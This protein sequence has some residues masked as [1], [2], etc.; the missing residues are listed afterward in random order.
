MHEK[1]SFILII[2]E[3]LKRYSDANNPLSQ[4]DIAKYAEQDYSITISRKAIKSNLVELIELGYD[5]D[6]AETKRVGKNGIEDTI[7]SD[8]YFN[9]DFSDAELRFLIDYLLSTKLLPYSQ[10]MALIQKLENTS[11]MHF[12]EKMRATKALP[13]HQPEKSAFFYNLELLDEAIFHEKKISFKL[14]LPGINSITQQIPAGEAT[15]ASPYELLTK[16][17]KHYLFFSE[18]PNKN[19]AYCDIENL[20]EIEILDK[21]VLPRSEAEWLKYSH[22]PLMGMIGFA[23]E[24][25]DVIFSLDW[26]TYQKFSSNL[27]FLDRDK[28][29]I[30]REDDMVTITA[31]V[32]ED[33]IIRWALCYNLDIHSPAKIRDKVREAV[34]ELKEKYGE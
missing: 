33:L 8:W 23:D 19:L 6:Y 34:R 20:T 28:I 18:D 25:E 5:I 14:V 16:K 27:A 4:K 9:H 1:K 29:K 15:V 7:C 24:G 26:Q 32:K 13:E 10:R 11:S 2:L 21:P 31:P 3:V 17:G 30:K 22:D 12:R